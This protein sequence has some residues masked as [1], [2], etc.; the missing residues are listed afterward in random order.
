MS[1]HPR[2]SNGP[3]VYSITPLKSRQAIVCLIRLCGSFFLTFAH[4][5][6][7][8][9]SSPV[10]ARQTPVPSHLGESS[11]SSGK[12]SERE[13]GMKRRLPGCGQSRMSSSDLRGVWPERVSES[14]VFRLFACARGNLSPS[15]PFRGCWASP[16]ETVVWTDKCRDAGLSVSPR[17]SEEIIIPAQIAAARRREGRGPCSLTPRRRWS[18]G[19]L[20]RDRR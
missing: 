13:G 15:V 18:R 12:A 17:R 5:Q 16:S 1:A 9:C 14:L 20:L 11:S 10:Y 6:A 2:E 19:L 4:G 7:L 3:L 8:R